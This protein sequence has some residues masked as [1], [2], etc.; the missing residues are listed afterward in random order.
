MNFLRPQLLSEKKSLLCGCLLIVLP[1]SVLAIESDQVLG[2]VQRVDF[3]PALVQPCFPCH[4]PQGQ[5]KASAI[6]SIAGLPRNYLVKVL[7]AYQHGGR[8]GTV[9]D[10]LMGAYDRT[11]IEAMA[12][13]FSSQPYTV[14]KQDTDWKQVDRGRQLHQW[15]CKKCHGDARQPAENG[16]PLLYG[17]WM[18]YLRWT[19]QDYL[20]GINLG[21]EE[22]NRKLAQMMRNH[23]R[24]GLEALL[25]YYGK[26]R[27]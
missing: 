18:E 24:E 3:P 27:P 17:R 22:M 4:G 12:D 5:S 1:F 26:G 14:S 19:L 9:M 8:F 10:R 15:Y 20:I 2:S 13:Y 7:R 6:P 21:D 25:H 23:G 11:Q 16:A